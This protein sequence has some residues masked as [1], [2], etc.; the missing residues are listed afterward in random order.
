MGKVPEMPRVFKA[1][2]T[3]AGDETLHVT[4]VQRHGSGCD[5]QFAGSGDLPVRRRDASIGGREDMAG[6]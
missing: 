4:P 6:S 5:A 1:S 2:L 3:T